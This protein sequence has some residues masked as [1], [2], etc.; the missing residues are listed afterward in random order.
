VSGKVEGRI[1]FEPKGEGGFGY[2]PL[3]IYP[4]EGKTFGLLSADFKNGVSHRANALKELRPALAGLL[5]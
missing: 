2:D 4:P 5:Q 1:D 3:F